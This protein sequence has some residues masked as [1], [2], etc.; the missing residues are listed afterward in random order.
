[1]ATF[2]VGFFFQSFYLQLDSTLH[3]LSNRFS[4]YSV[5]AQRLI[6]G[7]FLTRFN[8]LQPFTPVLSWEGLLQVLCPRTRE[9]Q[10]RSWAAR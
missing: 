2:E 1:M 7:E 5:C 6:Y 8:S 3:G 9:S 4:F 10:T